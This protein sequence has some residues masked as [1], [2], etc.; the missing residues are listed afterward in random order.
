[1]AG[2][3]EAVSRASSGDTGMQRRAENKLEP[4]GT[5]A[6]APAAS[7]HNYLPSRTLVSRAGL[8]YKRQDFPLNL[9]C[10]S[11]VNNSLHKYVPCTI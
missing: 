1:M 8:P 6:L 5:S 7:D 3:Q 10:A 9:N 2:R 11:T 4:P